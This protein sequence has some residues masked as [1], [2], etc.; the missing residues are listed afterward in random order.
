[1]LNSIIY[2]VE[3]SDDQVKEYAANVLTENMLSQV[4]AQ[5]F[6]TTL[7]DGIVDYK[8]DETAVEKAD[9]FL[10]TPRGRRRLRQTTTGWKLLVAWKDGS[11]TWVPLKDRK[12]SNPVDVAEF[13]TA[14]G[15]ED[16]PAFAWW[17]P[18]TL[19]K[20]ISSYTK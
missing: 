10:V 18:Y 5:G 1:M 15:I 12:E 11:E 19:K 20:G 8:K 16:E 13:A 6:S 4:D 7:F 3:F 2:E 14:R 9:R 17:V